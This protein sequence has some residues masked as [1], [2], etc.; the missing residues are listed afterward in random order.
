MIKHISVKKFEDLIHSKSFL[1]NVSSWFNKFISLFFRTADMIDHTILLLI[2]LVF[3]Q[4][5]LQQLNSQINDIVELV[6]GKLNKG[7]RI[8]LGALTVLDVHGM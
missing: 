2:T 5:Y 6:R 1:W 3:F 4:N 8:T 7:S